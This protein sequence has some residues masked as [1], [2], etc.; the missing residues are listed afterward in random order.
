[1]P[2]KDKP[3]AGAID[4]L[5]AAIKGPEIV[6]LVG[7]DLYAFYPDGSGRSK[8]TIGL[9]EKKLGSKGTSRNWNT[10]LK[11]AEALTGK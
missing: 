3:A 8:L 6:E 10:A 2:L 1:M 5:R 9:I 4:E 11:I 7:R